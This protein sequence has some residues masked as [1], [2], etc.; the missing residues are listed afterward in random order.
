[1][2]PQQCRNQ[3]KFAKAVKS[4]CSYT[5]QPAVCSIRCITQLPVSTIF[6]LQSRPWS[7]HCVIVATFYHSIHISYINSRLWSIVCL[8]WLNV[9]IY[10][11]LSDVAHLFLIQF[12][13]SWQCEMSVEWQTSDDQTLVISEFL[14]EQPWD[15]HLRETKEPDLFLDAASTQHTTADQLVGKVHLATCTQTNNN[16]SFSFSFV[17]GTAGWVESSWVRRFNIR[18]YTSQVILET[19]IPANLLTGTKQGRREWYGGHHTDPK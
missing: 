16:T 13:L 1:M 9:S 3:L 15:N 18:L 2:T 6:C 4:K 8:T 10:R 12:S 14:S 7:I 17:S 11:L 5:V 19:N